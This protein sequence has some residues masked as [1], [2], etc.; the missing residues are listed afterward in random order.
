MR[1]ATISLHGRSLAAVILADERALVL[2]A[3]AK[4]GGLAPDLAEVLATGS[5]Q[6]LI[7][8]G[9]A[10]IDGVRRLEAAAQAGGLGNAIVAAA[11][12][13][14]RAPLPQ[15]VKNVF[16]VGRNYRE[17]IAEGERAENVT[18]GVSENPVFFTK[19]QTAVVGPNET[20]PIFPNVS[21]KID[22]E[23][24]LAVVIGKRGRDIPA[25]R[26]YEYVL[27]YTILNDVTARDVQRAHGGQYFKGKG[28]DGS[29]PIGPWI[30]TADAIKDPAALGLSTRIN[31]ELRQDG[32]TSDMIFDI[33]TLIASLSKGLTLDPGDILATGTPAGVGYAMDP[34]SWLKDGD[35]MVLEIEGIGRL[36]NRMRTE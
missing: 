35:V 16:C 27:G 23:V 31:G 29:C 20:V 36:E 30:V 12:V 4:A 22:Y 7:D 19:P 1:L 3:A 34:P 9:P 5:L 33:P 26:A 25:E 2:E 24:E 15:P 8:A 32:T 13:V 18:V 6:A 10:A 17:H 11:D 14:L 28:L 21:T